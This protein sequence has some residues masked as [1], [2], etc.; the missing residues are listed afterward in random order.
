MSNIN[1]I[2]SGS[3]GDVPKAEIQ[4]D[5]TLNELETTNGEA[6]V[7]RLLIEK[8]NELITEVNTLKN[9]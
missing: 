2:N 4:I 3:L 9:S 1:S 5:K 8:I 7:F 6:Y